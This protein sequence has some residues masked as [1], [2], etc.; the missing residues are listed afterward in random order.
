MSRLITRCRSKIML[1][2][3]CLL[4]GALATMLSGMAGEGKA[5]RKFT[6]VYNVNNAGYIDVCGCKHKEVRQGSMTR[7]ASFLKQLKA[8]GRD[9][10]LLDG[11]SAFFPINKRL[12][13]TEI[14]EA[15]RKAELIAESYNRIGYSA[16][17]I[18]PY[19][20]IT[21][22]ENLQRLQKK[23]RFEMLSANF[24]GKD[25]KLLFKPHAVFEA[26][27][28]RVGVIG[29]TLDTIPGPV[30]EKRAPGCKILDP[31][32]AAKKS[33]EALRPKTDIIIALSHLKEDT[34][35]ELIE[36][37]KGLEIV[38]DPY[39]QQGSHK[40]WLKEEVEWLEEKNDTLFLRSDGQGAR[41]GVVD[42][43][44][45]KNGKTLYSGARYDELL[46]LVEFD[47]A[48]AEEKKEL[49]AYKGENLYRFTRISLE[50]HHLT[51]PEI[52]QLVNAWKKN[53]DL[54]GVK[55]LEKELPEKNRYL[56]HKACKS[57]HEKQYA[58]WLTTTHS[59]TIDE[60]K[61]T[62]DEAR[63]DCIG[64]HALGYGKAFLDT[65]NV[66][67]YANVQCE[68]CH[69][70]Q[71]E[72]PKKPAEHSFGKV[73][74]SSCIVCH[75]QEQTRSIFQFVPARKKVACPKG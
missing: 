37:L 61:K 32:A 71:P 65:T 33:Y 47:E 55:Q 52:D 44:L 48:N 66:G 19:D 3:L 22:L 68:S 15:F 17:A 39:I 42:V 29:L 11:G 60:L 21:G 43:E 28:I 26:G 7:R 25:G 18:G 62:G 16:M 36:K 46:D 56:T 59:H 1:V 63:Y 58:F 10:L 8:T 67:D 9:L 50:P 69:G 27:G 4:L 30:L 6:L 51:D 75:N 74:R 38:I 54:S 72:H 45:F 64:C 49:Q 70:L 35:F 5:S 31:F 2:P 23:A 41:L 20:L 12:K 57:C 73:A 14:K 24:A 53:I 40:T 34:N 13:P